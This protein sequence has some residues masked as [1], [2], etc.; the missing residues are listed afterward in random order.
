MKLVLSLVAG[1]ALGALGFT[2]SGLASKPPSPPGKDPCSHGNTGRECRPDPQPERGKDCDHHG[3]QGGVNEDH[4]LGTTETTTTDDTTTE[5]TTTTPTPTAT[6]NLT[7][8]PIAGP[9]AAKPPVKG[10]LATKPPESVSQNAV[11]A[12]ARNADAPKAKKR[13]V[14][15]LGVKKI[16]KRIGVQLARTKTLPFTK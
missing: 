10:P 14:G 12:A 6:T 7:T 5:A 8:P 3:K 4:C 2:A 16:E 9:P 11:A 15:V 13:S 1:L